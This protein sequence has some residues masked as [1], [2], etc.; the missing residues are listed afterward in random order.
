MKWKTEYEEKRVYHE[1]Q[2]FIYYKYEQL[3]FA[4]SF[5]C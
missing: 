5:E 2:K 1:M 4:E 3:S